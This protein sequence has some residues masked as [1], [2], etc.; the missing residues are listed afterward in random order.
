MRS[1]GCDALPEQKGLWKPGMMPR[2]QVLATDRIAVLPIRV[3]KEGVHT[4]VAICR[5]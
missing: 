5:A 4:A 2:L 3:K 1:Y